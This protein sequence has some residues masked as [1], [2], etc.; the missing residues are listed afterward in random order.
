[1]RA[2]F[3]RS[4]IAE[5]TPYEKRWLQDD[6]SSVFSGALDAILACTEVINAS[7]DPKIN[8]GR[9][10]RIVKQLKPDELRWA[11]DELC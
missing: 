10:L 9:L 1:M 7:L 11:L 5:L 2:N 6:A 4:L 3:V 8:K